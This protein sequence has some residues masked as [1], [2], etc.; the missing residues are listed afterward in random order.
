M[1]E[2]IIDGDRYSLDAVSPIWPQKSQEEFHRHVL[3][4][5]K[6][7]MAANPAMTDEVIRSFTGGSP[8]FWPG[9]FPAKRLRKLCAAF[10]YIA[11]FAE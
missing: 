2:V 7:A 3:D 8:V 4:R 9:A 5:C 11:R 6:E 1:S 10:F